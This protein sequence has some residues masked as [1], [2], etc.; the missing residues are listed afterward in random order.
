MKLRNAGDVC[1]I[2]QRE[3]AT[4]RISRV[5]PV[6]GRMPRITYGR[7]RPASPPRTA[8]QYICARGHRWGEST[9]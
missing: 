5:K 3:G 7:L 4:G 6:F 1:P 9:R 8:T 2:C